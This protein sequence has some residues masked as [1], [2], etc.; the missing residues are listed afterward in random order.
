MLVV[1]M[2]VVGPSDVGYVGFDGDDTEAD[3][4]FAGTHNQSQIVESVASDVF[5]AS[6]S[7]NPGS[8]Y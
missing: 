3:R 8:L 1:C 7:Y 4:R 2:C 6:L 5:P